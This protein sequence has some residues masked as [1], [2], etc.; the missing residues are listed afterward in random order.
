MIEIILQNHLQLALS[1]LTTNA[2]VQLIKEIWEDLFYLKSR[3]DKLDKSTPFLIPVNGISNLATIQNS[4]LPT[5]LGIDIQSFMHSTTLPIIRRLDHHQLLGNLQ[6][7]Y[8]LLKMNC[9]KPS[10]RLSPNYTI[11]ELSLLPTF[12][13][14]TDEKCAQFGELILSA[15]T[16]ETI[17]CLRRFPIV[18]NTKI[19]QQ[20]SPVSATFDETIVH[21]FSSLPRITVPSHCRALAIKLGVCV[22]YDL[23]TCVTILQLLSNEKNTNIDLYIQWLGHLQLYV[24]QQHAEFNSKELL[25]SCQLY[26]PD[27]QKF[28]S[29]KDLLVISNDDEHRNGILLVSKYLKLQ[30]ISPS[31]N[32]VYWQFKDLFRLL[33]C[34]CAI[35]ITNIYNTIYSASQDKSNFYALGDCTTTLTENGMESMIVLFQYLEDLLLKCVKENPELYH[36]VVQNKHLTAPC[37]S[38]EDLKWRFGFTCNSLSKQLWKVSGIQQLQRKKIGLLTIDRQMITKKTTNII[39]ACLETKIIQNLSKDT[40]KRYFISPLIART[41]PLVVAAFGID[42]IERRGKIEWKHKNHNLEYVLQ[43]LTDIFRAA[44]NDSE[45]E[46]VTAK[47]ASVTL[48]LSDDS[49]IDS[50]DED[51]IDRY[52]VDSDYPFWIFNKLILLCT[53]NEKDDAS[54][55]I[56]ATSALVTL[57]HKRKH[58]PFEEAKSI[59]RQR[60]STC[61]AFR[62]QYVSQVAS[63]EST[64][65]SYTDLLF[66][67][68]HHSIES[69]I[70]SIGK[71]CTIEQDLEDN[72]QITT[73][74]AADRIAEDRVYRDRVKTADH[75]PRN[76]NMA[77][78]WN[79][80]A[81]VDG[82]EHIRIGQN[83]EHFF[84]TYL[85]SRY[86]L[87]DVTPTNNW[88]SSSRL[89]TY[90]QCRR[91]VNDAAGFDFELHD[92]RELF[93]RG[94]GSTT[95]YC[96]FEVKGTS[97]SFNEAQTCFHISQ[98]ELDTCQSIAD[99]GRRREREAYFIVIIQ[100]CLDAEKICFGTT[101]NW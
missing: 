87:V 77:N 52:M 43:Q 44:L 59:A 101:I 94:S 90:P 16:D 41:C 55:A 32:Q 46:V 42:Y 7:E 67:T 82:I 63:T 73:T 20:I 36:A 88:R 79:D 69:L 15:H 14:F 49:T 75:I 47:Y 28:Y 3:L 58:L 84:F 81:I 40:G 60:I 51:K 12:I 1:S 54:R 50:V 68:D 31:I 78:N 22:E 9:Q 89:V 83:A 27:Q 85:Q 56:I 76:G 29:L 18:D 4:I 100:N 86:G 96:Y 24:R 97:G 38:Q 37:G 23:R 74:V 13:M 66:P 71:Y 17:D 93:V 61:T 48:L 5:I 8:F 19:E 35:N 21:D 98:N 34:T 57:L 99:D 2:D 91:N 64:I 92:T 25:S 72:T 70:I 39:Y 45:L 11:A 33:N 80:P 53:G 65:H 6:W 26:L 10:I 30:I 62:S 95:K